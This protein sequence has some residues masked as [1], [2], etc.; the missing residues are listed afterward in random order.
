MKKN[1][2]Q[3]EMCDRFYFSVDRRSSP[4]SDYFHADAPTISGVVRFRSGKGASAP[5]PPKRRGAAR[6]RG[7]RPRAAKRPCGV[8]ESPGQAAGL[9]P[10]GPAPPPQG[11][12][13]RALFRR[14][15]S[16]GRRGTAVPESAFGAP[17][18]GGRGRRTGGGVP[19][20][21]LDPARTAAEFA[22]LRMRGARSG[23]ILHPEGGGRRLPRGSCVGRAPSGGVFGD[24]AAGAGRSGAA[25]SSRGAGPSRMFRTC[26]GGAWFGT[27][28]RIGPG[29]VS[30]A[31]TRGQTGAGGG[32]TAADRDARAMRIG[33]LGGRPDAWCFARVTGTTGGAPTGNRSRP[34]RG[35]RRR[36]DSAGA[37]A[38]ERPGRTRPEASATSRRSRRIAGSFGTTP[39]RGRRPADQG[40][41]S[42]ARFRAPRRG[43]FSFRSPRMPTLG[44]SDPEGVSAARRR[45][46]SPAPRIARAPHRPRPASH[47]TRPER[48]PHGSEPPR[49]GASAALCPTGRTPNRGDA[50]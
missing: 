5:G 37:P 39:L 48:D 34:T 20:D 16:D 21:G 18:Q 23:R 9:T 6:R 44:D 50:G 19:P 3:Q 22:H 24:R 15:S 2:Y 28:R 36:T 40:E 26:C 14:S 13:R 17:S 29:L 42:A 11:G 10:G 12:D 7:A 8:A 33:F 1:S 41:A 43:L 45:P 27:G 47:P 31:A 4:G 32:S 46:A 38:L 49:V 25:E 30:G 35:G